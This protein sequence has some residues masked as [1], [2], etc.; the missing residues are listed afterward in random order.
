MTVLEAYTEWLSQQSVFDPI[1]AEI[2]A[3]KQ[4]WKE[5][6]TE[7]KYVTHMNKLVQLF[8]E[9]VPGKSISQLDEAA[10]IVAN[11]QKHRRWNTATA[12]INA[13]KPTH[14]IISV[15]LMPKWLMA[16]FASDLGFS[17][18]IGSTY[19]TRDGPYTEE[20]HGINKAAEYA[21]IRDG[22]TSKP[23]IHMRDT[24]GDSPLFAL[25]KRPILFNPSNTLLASTASEVMTTVTSHKDVVVIL[26]PSNES[27]IRTAKIWGPPF[28]AQAILREVQQKF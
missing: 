26:N 23:D 15:S 9:Q 16:P 2:L 5:D 11:Q 20:A 28:D 6:N 7:Q 14:N 4:V 3:A 8:I 21:K 22:D 25:A 27:G 12:I 1:P 13:V 17:A 10:N 24:V 18:L 19:V